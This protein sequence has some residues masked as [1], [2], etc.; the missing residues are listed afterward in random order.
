MSQGSSKLRAFCLILCALTTSIVV[1]GT[2][3]T[4]TAI[5]TSGNSASP[6]AAIDG[7][8]NLMV[9]FVDQG[10]VVFAS[11]TSQF[12][13]T[14]VLSSSAT[15]PVNPRIAANGILNVSIVYAQESLA[16]GATGND[17]IFATSSGGGFNGPNN[18][19]F[20]TVPDSVP[21]ASRTNSGTLHVAYQVDPIGG[22]EVHTNLP[23]TG[24]LVAL[25]SNPALAET[26]SLTYLGYERNGDVFIRS[27]DGVAFSPEAIITGVTG[28]ST[29]IDL[30]ADGAG[31]VHAVFVNNGALHYTNNSG[32][33]FAAA[34]LVD[35][36][37]VQGL[38]RVASNFGGDI[39]LAY[40]VGGQI[41]VREFSAGAFTAAVVYSGA[42]T[43]AADPAVA[44]DG[45]GFVRVVYADSGTIYRVNNVPQPSVDFSATPTSGEILLD[46]D[47]TN[48]SSGFIE[49]YLWDFG[50]GEISIV[51]SPSHVYSEV[52]SYDVS[53]TVTGPGGSATMTVPNYIVA[54]PPTN[55]LSFPDLKVTSP[56]TITHP[57]LT[58]HPGE[59]QGFQVI[60][61]FNNNLTTAVNLTITGTFTDTVLPEFLE[62]NY[63]IS[64]TG[65]DSYLAI[66]TIFDVQEPFL[67][68]TLPPGNAQTIGFFE[69][70]IPAGLPVGLTGA[71]TLVDGAYPPGP[72]PPLNNVIAVGGASLS[73]FLDHAVIEVVAP[74]TKFLRGDAN[75]N[76]T[77]D[78]SDT[79]FILAFLFSGGTAP[80]CPDAADPNDTGAIDIADAVYLLGYL[81]SNGAHPRY[82]FP[83]L[84]L[85]PSDD[86]L[87]PCI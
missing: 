61:E 2:P 32:G 42:T 60:A 58:S 10:Q 65:V 79:V 56:D 18:F 25:G 52:G 1:A 38:P 5:T 35:A 82:P 8:G 11:S 77:I 17:I 46:V 40:A 59:V 31:V 54:Q 33:S 41:L 19:T 23:G 7:L 13:G 6:D 36:G 80:S 43:T 50:D 12:A 39:A 83:A 57:I 20:D 48:L 71:I 75:S 63:V 27:H 45:N 69:Y 26:Q 81:F 28:T 44:V 34:Q 4:P 76:G 72:A 70:T 16:P 68:Q 53:L 73:P 62:T 78:L 14:L 55:I 30:A 51:Q 66:V 24:T 22:S 9:T 74:S 85:D 84:G 3:N 87:G 67:S 21:V 47:F 64:P 29:L 15:P 49:Q 37:P 86:L